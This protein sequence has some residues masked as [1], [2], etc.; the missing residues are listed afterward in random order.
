MNGV[1]FGT[2]HSYNDLELILNSKTIGQPT[3]KTATVDIPG[4]DGELDY[5]EYFGDVKYNNR[6]L[7][8]EFSTI[9]KPTEFLALF[10]RLQNLFN[11][12]KT[13][14]VLDD[15]PDFYYVGR[16]FVNEWKTNGRIGKIVIDVNAEPYKYR[17]TTTVISRLLTGATTITCPNSRMQVI[18]TI[19]A[20]DEVSVEFG[21]TVNVFSGQMPATLAEE[22]IFREGENVLKVAPKKGSA[23]ITIEYREGEL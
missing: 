22:I 5:T 16:V 23:V 10:S 20:S 11:G 3:P 7:S 1:T 4:G 2:L 17:Q 14:I 18:P 19:T 9:V 12:R 21:E 13:T 6:T 15:D 8:F